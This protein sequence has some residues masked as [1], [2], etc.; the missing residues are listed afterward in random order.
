MAVSRARGIPPV[1]L[2]AIVVDQ[3]A[4]LRAKAESQAEAIHRHIR[5]RTKP[6]RRTRENEK[7][8]LP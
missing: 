4:R 6:T 8:R 7:N 1:G 5:R 3:L 2:Q